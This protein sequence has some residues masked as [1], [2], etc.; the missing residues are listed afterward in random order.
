MTSEKIQVDYERL[1]ELERSCQDQAENTRQATQRVKSRVDNLRQ[2]GWSGEGAAAFLREMDQDVFPAM[3][4][5]QEALLETADVMA[6][7]A[8]IFAEAEAEG[9]ALFQRDDGSAAGQP[10]SGIIP[11]PGFGIIR[12][13]EQDMWDRWRNRIDSGYKLFEGFEGFR[14]LRNIKDLVNPVKNVGSKAGGAA[15][16]AIIDML[17]S[18]DPDMARRAYTAVGSNAIMVFT[19]GLN[20]GTAIN[21]VYQGAGVVDVTAQHFANDFLGATPQVHAQLERSTAD[22]AGAYQRADLSNLFQDIVRTH[23][24]YATGGRDYWSIV[25]NAASNPNNRNLTDFIDTTRNLGFGYMSDQSLLTRNLI[26][27]ATNI[28]A[29]GGYAEKMWDNTK[30]I[31]TDIVNVPVGFAES[32]GQSQR[33]IN[34]GIASAVRPITTFP[35]LPDTWR[36]NVDQFAGGLMK[37]VNDRPTM[38]DAIPA[39]RAF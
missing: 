29:G 36:S 35:L 15:L 39:P 34:V 1:Q 30:A 13:P 14:D 7:V 5:L 19:P 24:D 28:A 6:V 18:E 3:L 23:Y 2:S 32:F 26:R 22:V 33:W 25:Q 38:S 31:G 12:I 8:R 10:G 11:R 16:G 9:A 21:A 4:R 27:D 37:W 17:T 20:I